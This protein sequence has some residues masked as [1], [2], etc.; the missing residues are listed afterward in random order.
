MKQ[1]KHHPW[2]HFRR[3][4]QAPLRR[5]GIIYVGGVQKQA[6]DGRPYHKRQTLLRTGGGSGVLLTP[7][8]L[9]ELCGGRRVL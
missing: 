4:R 5:E 3:L 6:E 9:D 2:N 1:T 8:L 7:E